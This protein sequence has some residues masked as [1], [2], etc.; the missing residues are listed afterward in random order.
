MTAAR[1]LLFIPIVLLT[2]AAHLALGAPTEPLLPGPDGLPRGKVRGV[3]AAGPPLQADALFFSTARMANP[4][5]PLP[6][7]PPQAALPSPAE[8]SAVQ[9]QAV[10]TPSA[11]CRAPAEQVWPALVMNV[12]SWFAAENCGEDQEREA[13]EKA[14]AP[15]RRAVT[16]VTGVAGVA[17]VSRPI[18][19]YEN[20][21]VG[22]YLRFYLKHNREEFEKG[23]RRSG[24]YMAMILE[25]FAAGEI[26]AELAYLAA[27]ES[28][29]N[30]VA[31][32]HAGAVGMW[33]FMPATAR[34]FGLRVSYPWYDER[35]DPELSTRAAARLLAHLHD[36]YDSWELALAAYNAGEGRVNRALRRARRNNQPEDFWNL[37][38][39]PQTRAYVP[40]FLAMTKLY[41]ERGDYGF[42]QVQPDPPLVTEELGVNYSTSLA[43]IAGRLALPRRELIRLNRAWRR[44]YIPENFR[45]KVVLRLPQGASKTLLASMNLEPAKPLPWLTH[46]VEAGETLSHIAKGYRISISEI[47][48]VNTMSNRHLLSVGQKLVIPLAPEQ[49]SILT[50]MTRRLQSAGVEIPPP[51][52]VMHLHQVRSGESLWSISRYYGVTMG[53]LRRW[54]TGTYK[55][56]HPEQELVVFL[57]TGA[58]S[59]QNG[60]AAPSS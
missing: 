16:G 50:E 19:I 13:G 46:L 59:R 6:A 35:L 20:D 9:P 60:P 11:S 47:L 5:A 22:N 52:T 18:A 37:H 29:F 42:G 24:R 58:D 1:T 21:I 51:E 32:S 7:A 3:E 39:P 12:R 28:N 44:G 25:I 56:I 48:S 45:Y 54:N 17:S 36:R 40:S 31:R 49:G 15:E 26:P 33:Q 10:L 41:R 30:P 4:S 34:R 27:V 55:L 23:L 43:D 8:L 14:E 38:L 53:Q 57:P 2:A